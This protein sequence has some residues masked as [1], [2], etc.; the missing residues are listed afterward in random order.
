MRRA[1]W[2]AALGLVACGGGAQGAG[3]DRSLDRYLG[4][5]GDG[6]WTWRDDGLVEEPDEATLLHGREGASGIELRRGSRWADAEPAGYFGLVVDGGLALDGWALGADSGG[7]RRP[8]AN[9]LLED[10]ARVVDGDWTCTTTLDAEI[11]TFYA[12]FDRTLVLE[13]E[14]GGFPA[15]TWAFAEDIGLVSVVGQGATLELVAPW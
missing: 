4:F 1:A 8:M 13:C 7:A 3:G 14:G 10:G 6:A 2:L 5:D 9:A 11:E 12:V 15:G